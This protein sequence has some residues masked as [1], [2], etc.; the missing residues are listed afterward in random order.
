MSLKS[1]SDS[2]LRP[3]QHSN[4]TLYFL[5]AERPT[6]NCKVTVLKLSFISALTNGRI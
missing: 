1:H 4:N 5:L 2:R 3:S 6:P